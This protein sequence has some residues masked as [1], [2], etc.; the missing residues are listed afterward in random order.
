MTHKTPPRKLYWMIA[1]LLLLF[2]CF[3]T[4]MVQCLKLPP[5]GEAVTVISADASPHAHTPEEPTPEPSLSPVQTPS[6]TPFPTAEPKE[7]LVSS[8]PDDP[9]PELY[10][11]NPNQEFDVSEEYTIY[12]T[13][14]DGPSGSTPALL[15]VLREECVPAT[16]FILEDKYPEILRQAY[17]DGHTLGVHSDS[18]TYQYVYWNMESFLADFSRSY[19]NIWSATGYRPRIFR[20]PGGSVNSYNRHLIWDLVT[21]M[22]GRGFVYHDWNVTSEDASSAKTYEEQLEALLKYSEKKTRII[23]LM[24][25]TDKNPWI[26]ELVREYIHIMKDRGYRFEALSSRVEPIHFTMPTP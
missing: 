12:L 11:D 24:H 25:D 4:A 23:A 8:I 18:H 22:E 7:L 13:F 21:E 16:F 2:V 5:N 3:L 10:G 26:A 9:Y 1:V 20:F 19:H 14:D 17:K 6:H 15:D